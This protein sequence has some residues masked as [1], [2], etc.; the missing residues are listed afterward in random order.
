MIAPMIWTAARE[1]A[2]P[3]ANDAHTRHFYE[4]VGVLGVEET[5]LWGEDTPCLTIVKPL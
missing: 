5:S 4:T 1:G 2:L 3:D